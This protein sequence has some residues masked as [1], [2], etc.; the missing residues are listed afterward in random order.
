M[1]ALRFDGELKLVCDA[2]IPRREGETLIQVIAAGI[3]NTDLEITKGYA[4][5]RGTL[6]HEFVG[7][8]VESGDSSLVGQRVVGEINVGCG[9]CQ[10]CKEGDARH[11]PTRT[12]LGIKGR[13]GAFAEFLSLPVGNLKAVPRS[14]SDETAVFVEPLAAALNILEQVSITPSSDV[15]IV[16]DGKLAQ[17]IVLALAQTGS[18]ISVIGRHDEKLDLA[19]RLGAGCV[20]RESAATGPEWNGRFDVAIE[21]SGAPSGLGTALRVVKP[22][23]TVVLKSTHHGETRVDTSRVVVN[24][25]TIVGSRCGRFA[26]A[27]DLLK[28]E[29]IDLNPLISRRLPLE[30]GLL[31]FQEAAA[32]GTMKVILQVLERVP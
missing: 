4:G 21:A 24:E 9:E 17:L 14:V 7:R 1:K 13:D 22:R 28:R 15:V 27:I 30:E 26:P 29:R 11:C 6:G 12:V 3:C 31:A 5:F 2:P 23:G 32:P 16:G 18:S 19:E 20:L 10:L 25:V 8:V